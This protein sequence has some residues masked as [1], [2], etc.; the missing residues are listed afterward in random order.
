[1]FLNSNKGR[2]VAALAALAI[3]FFY[4]LG[5]GLCSEFW[6]SRDHQQIYLLGLKFYTTRWW[7]Y[8]GPDVTQTMQI[9]GALQGLL[10]GLPFFVA[11]IPEAPFILVSLLSFASLSFFA[12]YCGRRFPKLPKWLVWSWVLTLPW[13]LNV[14]TTTFNPSYVLP[15]GIV[16]FVA[17]LELYPFTTMGLIPATICNVMMAGAV[18]WTMQ[19]HLSW[20]LLVPYAALALY[21]QLRQRQFSALLWFVVGAVVPATLLLPTFF[22]Y[23]FRVGLGNT[24]DAMQINL[25]NVVAA[26]NPVEG[27]LP[28]FL[29]FASYEIPRFI[30]NNTT[31][32][33]AFLRAN[34]W[35][36][37]FAIFLTALGIVQPI[38]LIWQWFAN[39][40]SRE[41]WKAIKYCALATV[42][43]LCVAFMFSMKLPAAHTFYLMIPIV[44]LYALYAWERWLVKSS[45]QRFAAAA[46]ACSIIFHAGLAL[47]NLPATSIY[48][49][50][51]RIVEALEKKD[52]QIVGERPAGAKY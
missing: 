33:I 44:L 9:P 22:K 39:K 48:E 7:P 40:S 25:H 21:F 5:F 8:F 10:V 52:F 38:H 3:A 35:L 15:A 43:W 28:R 20:V 51:A 19:L 32:R 29:S 24:G 2:K 31:T 50:R 30:G 26:L 13:T 11:P 16:F 23:G 45:W 4:R 36:I 46:I 37:P 49:D 47:R 1:L 12:W 6:T 42:A 17:V 34:P 41:D 14:S 18:T 27:V